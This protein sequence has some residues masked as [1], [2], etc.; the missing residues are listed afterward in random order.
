MSFFDTKSEVIAIELTSL[1]KRLLSEG[2]FKPEF[3]EFYDDDVI[4]DSQ[5]GSVA[6]DN[7]DTGERIRNDTPSLKP[8]YMFYGAETSLK[9][10]SDLKDRKKLSITDSHLQDPQ[11]QYTNYLISPLG[12]SDII[13]DKIPAWKLKLL[14]G[15]ISSS[16]FYQTSSLGQV[17]K[18][19]QINLQEIIY[20][21]KVEYDDGTGTRIFGDHEDTG[22]G[23]TAD[24]NYASSRFEDNSFIKIEDDYVLVDLMEL[25]SP[26]TKKNFEIEVFIEEN[27]P[28][29][30]KTVLKPLYFPKKRNIIENDILLD[31]KDLELSNNTELDSS[32]VEYYFNIYVD[33]EIE[34]RILCKKVPDIDKQTAFPD[35]LLD[36]KDNKKLDVG[37][38]YTSDVTPEDLDDKC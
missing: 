1:G 25:N 28:V 36:C 33:E 17:V 21:T 3:Y 6:E 27:D 20:K 38:L 11:S 31:E 15:E 29:L 26:S 35:G 24:L 34:T 10:D 9:H 37:G 8:Q 13:S 18:I 4:Y 2:K 19:P 22:I 16:L 7:I 32:F 23:F 14:N 12:T 5:Y 30:D